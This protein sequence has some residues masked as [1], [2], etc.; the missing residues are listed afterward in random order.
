MKLS[1]GFGGEMSEILEEKVL[2][3]FCWF[4]SLFETK[5]FWKFLAPSCL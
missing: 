2:E 4:L 5:G 3:V 1:Q